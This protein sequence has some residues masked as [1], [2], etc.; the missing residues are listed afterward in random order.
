METVSV[1]Y[2]EDAVLEEAV[3]EAGSNYL[4]GEQSLEET[5][6]SIEKKASLYMKE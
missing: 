5:L 1:P 2:L 3:Y 6:D 4:R